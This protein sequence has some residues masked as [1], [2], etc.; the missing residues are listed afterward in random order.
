MALTAANPRETTY[1]ETVSSVAN[2]WAPE[3]GPGGLWR[4]PYSSTRLPSVWCAKPVAFQA[5]SLQPSSGVT[6]T[7]N[8][9]PVFPQSQFQGEHPL[10]EWCPHSFW[11]LLPLTSSSGAF[12]NHRALCDHHPLSVLLLS[13]SDVFLLPHLPPHPLCSTTQR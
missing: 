2:V 1:L 8:K 13:P 11:T 6:N 7:S 12:R 10:L 9:S 3:E 5:V 4:S